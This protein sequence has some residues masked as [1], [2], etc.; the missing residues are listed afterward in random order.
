M[1]AKYKNVLMIVLLLLPSITQ[2]GKSKSKSLTQEKNLAKID[3]D[4]ENL[5][6]K[7]LQHVPVKH[8][9]LKV[10]SSAGGFSPD[11][12]KVVTSGDSSPSKY[13]IKTHVWNAD[14]GRCLFS[15]KEKDYVMWDA[16]FSPVG[17]E[18]VIQE[19]Y[20]NEFFYVRDAKTGNYL[21]KSGTDNF[22][23]VKFNPDGTQMIYQIEDDNDL[24]MLDVQNKT[25]LYTLK[26]AFN[27]I[28]HSDGK[29]IATISNDNKIHVWDTKNGKCLRVFDQKCDGYWPL[30]FS[31][32][33]KIITTDS[34]LVGDN[35]TT[36]W[37]FK[38]G[39]RFV[40]A[41][42]GMFGSYSTVSSD[43]KRVAIKTSCGALCIWDGQTAKCLHVLKWL[44]KNPQSFDWVHARFG[45]KNKKLVTSSEDNFMRIWDIQDGTCLHKMKNNQ[46][47]DPI[48]SPDNNIIAISP[49]ENST[50]IIDVKTGLLIHVLKGQNYL[51]TS[52]MFSPDGTKTI[53]RSC[54]KNETYI[55][56]LTNLDQARAYLG[57]LLTSVQ[58]LALYKLC[59]TSGTL[60]EDDKKILQQFPEFI[61]QAIQK[62]RK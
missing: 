3:K 37:D 59:N 21:Y 9:T 52:Q 41:M 48:F 23:N 28:F 11:G 46:Y 34:A 60:K 16:Y 55:S 20:L 8:K 44:K 22:V 31:S 6:A 12:K 40:L 43:G 13:D 39:K 29:Y 24:H 56:D 14:T 10:G 7:I 19:T 33:G 30:N 27:P 51:L 25:C 58:T 18:I 62:L 26:N 36:M 45:Q 17:N 1:N 5:F 57:K 15:V 38:T 50:N 54:E 49:G 42:P 35:T 61:Q 4:K 2:A 47:N 32:D 53:T